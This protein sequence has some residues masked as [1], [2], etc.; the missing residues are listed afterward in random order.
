MFKIKDEEINN[1]FNINKL[2]LIY[3]LLNV[4]LIININLDKD[5]FKI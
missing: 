1:F 4:Y 2:L 5:I 3:T